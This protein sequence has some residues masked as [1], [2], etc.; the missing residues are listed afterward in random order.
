MGPILFTEDG[1]HFERQVVE[2][3]AALHRLSHHL[4]ATGEIM[5][6]WLKHCDLSVKAGLAP[7]IV[8]QLFSSW[9]FAACACSL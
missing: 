9:L 8:F 6:E 2:S 7:E 1:P 4:G 5:R 3:T